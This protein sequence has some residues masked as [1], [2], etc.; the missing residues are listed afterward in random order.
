MYR[1]SLYYSTSPHPESPLRYYLREQRRSSLVA[2]VPSPSRPLLFFPRPIP[3]LFLFPSRATLA[4]S[5]NRGQSFAKR[6]RTSPPR[7]THCVYSTRLCCRSRIESRGNTDVRETLNRACRGMPGEGTTAAA[8]HSRF[9]QLQEASFSRIYQLQEAMNVTTTEA[10]CCGVIVCNVFVL[11]FAA[12]FASDGS[13]QENVF[14]ERT[15]ANSDDQSKPPLNSIA[16]DA[17]TPPPIVV[18]KSGKKD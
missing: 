8:S 11:L 4:K 12:I 17:A 10:I 15:W 14:D 13:G 5:P 9:K 2:R 6:R 7:S 1:R 16:V 3:L 18:M